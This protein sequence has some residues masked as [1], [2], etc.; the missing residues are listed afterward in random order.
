MDRLAH[1]PGDR[2][3]PLLGHSV[4]FVRDCHRLMDSRRARYGDVFRTELLGRTQVMFLTPQATREIYLDPG[5]VLSSEGGWSTSLGPLFTR[6]LML[7]DFDDHRLHRRVMQQAFSRAALAGYVE[8]V[9]T[10]T[11]R[12]L[13]ALGPGEVDV[14]AVTKR[15]TL[16]IAAEVFVGVPLGEQ[17]DTVNRAF[18]DAIRA[19][20]TPVRLPLPGTTYA[21]GL[22]GR[23]TL[24]RVFGELVARRRAEEPR[25]DLLSRLAHATT[26]S[27]ETLPVDE[28]VDHMIFLVLAAHDT[29]TS[30]TAMLLWQLALH[31]DWQDRVTAEAAALD[32]A[33]VTPASSAGM[34]DTTMALHEALRLSPPVPFSPRLALEDVVITGVPVPAGTGV[35]AA[36]MTLHRH[37]DWW[38]EPDRFDPDRFAPGR[39]E[40]TAHSHL[41]VPFGGGAHLCIGN[42]VAELVVKAVVARLL[43]RHRVSADPAAGVV[44]Q[45]VPIPQPRGPLLLRLT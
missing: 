36:S 39:A 41:F 28:V 44:F 35:A 4:Q 37:P 43:A 15:L 45:P 38:S 11:D 20:V 5:Q 42:H 19:T 13:D 8:Q 25:A 34:V 24:Q 33:P 22:A 1:V 14:Y 40:H 6:G 7:R 21:R 18:S 9:H 16:D 2:G 29:T 32:G 12:H 17:A 31:A 3:A 27:G 26:D 30:T 10:V 23:R